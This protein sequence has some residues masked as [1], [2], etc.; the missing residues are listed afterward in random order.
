MFVV[1]CEEIR[2]EKVFIS[3]N[4]TTEEIK[5]KY[6][7][8]K[9]SALNTKKGDGSSRIMTVIFLFPIQHQ[10]FSLRDNRIMIP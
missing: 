6:N 5:E 1:E 4:M 7:I 10:V 2:R 9:S 3:Q 8:S